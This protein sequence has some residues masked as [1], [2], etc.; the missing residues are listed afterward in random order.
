[1]NT[2]LEGLKGLVQLL[3][4]LLQPLGAIN[5]APV[6]GLELMLELVSQFA[7]FN[8][9]LTHHNLSGQTIQLRTNVFEPSEA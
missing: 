9:E 3:E 1:M 2:I 5:S 8:Q 6:P 7:T 4:Q